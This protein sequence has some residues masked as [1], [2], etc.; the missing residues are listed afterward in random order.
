MPRR[1]RRSIANWHKLENANDGDDD[2]IATT[3]GAVATTV[4][5][6][7]A[8]LLA[9]VRPAQVPLELVVVIF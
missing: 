2:A 6:A 5:R 1:S 7:V 8:I 9:G 3:Q 4:A